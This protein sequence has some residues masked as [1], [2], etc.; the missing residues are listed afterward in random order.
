M[1][2]VGIWD[3]LFA[4]GMTGRMAYATVLTVV[5]LLII[6]LVHLQTNL[7]FLVMRNF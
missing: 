3:V 4:K 5:L 2:V 6:L 7:L 1:N